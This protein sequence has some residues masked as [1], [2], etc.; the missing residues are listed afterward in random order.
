[1]KKLF[2]LLAI[3]TTS[4]AFG[5]SPIVTKNI[6]QDSITGLNQRIEVFQITINSDASLVIV[7]YRIV[8]LSPNGT[9]VVISPSKT[10]TRFNE[11]GKMN[12]DILRA[13]LVG[14]TIIGMINADLEQYPHLEQ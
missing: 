1:M 12:F 9:T 14:Q 8:T 4:F 3:L 11:P 7:E 10:F 6:G 13:S 2:L 5:Q